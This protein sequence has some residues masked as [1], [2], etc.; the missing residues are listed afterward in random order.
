[1]GEKLNTTPR[2]RKIYLDCLRILATFA[3][4]IIHVVAD[5]WQSGDVFADW[6][7]ALTFFDSLV[8]WAVPVFVMISGALFLDNTKPLTYKTLY[9]KYLLR[10][11]TALV[12]WSIVYGVFYA[13]KYNSPFSELPKRCF[14][15]GFH[16]W[17]LYM[18]AGLYIITPILRK[19]TESK[20]T[21][22]YFLI[23]SMIFTFVIPSV[24]VELNKLKNPTVDVVTGNYNKL[25]F[26]LTLGYS[27]YFVLGY[28]LSKVNI[29]KRMQ[30]LIYFMGVIGSVVTI[31]LTIFTSRQILKP[32]G[33]YFG[34]LTVH[35]MLQSVAVFVFVKNI[36][37][38]IK[39]KQTGC[40]VV[41]ALSK[42]SF[43][44]YLV[45]IIVLEL[46]NKFLFNLDSF[47]IIL[48]TAAMVVSVFVGSLLVSFILNKIP[49]INKYNV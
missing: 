13:V 21:T 23:L 29:S 2:E 18:I 42:Y 16:L 1:M 5:K 38:K 34:Y 45:H 36:I 44:V 33:T 20:E 28:V 15:G 35:V 49:F 3:V 46:I 25:N 41:L 39:I 40:K 48:S 32:S 4:I 11:F 30:S 17:F 19:I 10:I 26:H 6:W 14:S 24:I 31:L 12:F 37:Y 9:G 7:V 43:G 22:R 47:N 27:A 8:R